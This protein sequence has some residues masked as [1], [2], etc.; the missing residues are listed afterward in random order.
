MSRPDTPRP[1]ADPAELVTEMV[2]RVLAL[3]ASWPRWD[4][5]PIEV[6]SPEPGEQRR[7]YTPHK[8]VRRVADH[9]IDH[10]AEMEARLGG[11]VTEPDRWH[12]SGTTTPADLAPFTAEDLDEARSRLRRLAQIWS[13]RIRPLGDDELD[14]K[15][16]DART[17]RELAVHLAESS[18]Y[19]EAVGE[20]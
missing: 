2:D 10:L 7:T 4:G 11:Q 20:L 17:I 19:A 12:G 14:R 6:D 5:K 8:A 15:Q 3:A 18:Y 13:V 16:E 9:L 1:G